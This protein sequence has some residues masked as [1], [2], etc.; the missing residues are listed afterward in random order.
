MEYV[1]IAFAFLAF[2]SLGIATVIGVKSP[3]D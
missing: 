3:S 2:T 1:M